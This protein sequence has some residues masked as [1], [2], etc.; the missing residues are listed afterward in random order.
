MLSDIYLAG[1][2]RFADQQN[3][4]EEEKSHNLQTIKNSRGTVAFILP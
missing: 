2:N 3:E 1:S 4:E